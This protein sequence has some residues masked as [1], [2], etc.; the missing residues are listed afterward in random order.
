MI[1]F[2]KVSL[3]TPLDLNKFVN[4]LSNEVKFTETGVITIDVENETETD[5]HVRLKIL[6]RILD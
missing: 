5:S 6:V 4:L 3:G 2:L 1:K